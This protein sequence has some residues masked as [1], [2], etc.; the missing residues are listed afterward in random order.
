MNRIP[1]RPPKTDNRTR[2]DRL[3]AS[4]IRNKAGAVK[5]TPA[6]R[7]S[8]TEAIVWT[9]LFSSI[10]TFFEKSLNAAIERTAAGMDAETVVPTFKPRYVFP[11]PKISPKK[12]PKTMA[13]KVISGV[14]VFEDINGLNLL[15]K[16]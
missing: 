3:G 11:I 8:P 10:E 7:P 16:N 6:A 5:I 13:L 2:V 15:I 14:F 12:Q 9:I 4:F 1:K